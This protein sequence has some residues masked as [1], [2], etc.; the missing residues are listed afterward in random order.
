MK[1]YITFLPLTIVL[2]SIQCTSEI[3]DTDNLVIDETITTE[4]VSDNNSTDNTKEELVYYK[5][6]YDFITVVNN[7]ENYGFSK[8]MNIGVL[9]SNY[10]FIIYLVIILFMFNNKL[11]TYIFIIAAILDAFLIILIFNYCL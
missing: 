9:H 4:I 1:K 6:N 8:G 5:N 7:K 2:I 11:P 3:E 10:D